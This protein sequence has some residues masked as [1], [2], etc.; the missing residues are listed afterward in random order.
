MVPQ[1]WLEDVSRR[2]L[3]DIKERLEPEAIYALITMKDYPY[4]YNRDYYRCRD[5]ALMSLLFM[6]V[7]RVNEVLR[8]TKKQ[9]DLMS[10]RQFIMRARVHKRFSSE[11]AQGKDYQKVRSEAH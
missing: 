4:K 11:Q 8:L 2:T 3:K 1:P 9:F 10:D 5:R 6:C 7:A